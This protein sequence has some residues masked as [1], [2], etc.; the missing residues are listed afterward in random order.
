V[1]FF[2]L[3]L[4]LVLAGCGAGHLIESLPAPSIPGDLPE[5]N[6]QQIIADNIATVF[7]DPG[8]LGTL[9]VSA[10]RPVN[11][12]RGPA[13]LACLKIHANEVPQE[14]ALFIQGDKIVDQ[15]TGVVM[16]RCKQQAYQPFDLA[17]FKQQKKAGR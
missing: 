9:E 7:P 13:W 4:S 17:S 2:A 5:P 10:V 1:R 11:H 14:Y 3:A 16:D 15:R 6:Y 12:L 8:G